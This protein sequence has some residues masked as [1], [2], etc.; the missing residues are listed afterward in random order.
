MRRLVNQ[1]LKDV[2]ESASPYEAAAAVIA[3]LNGSVAYGRS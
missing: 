3:R 2:D 1:E